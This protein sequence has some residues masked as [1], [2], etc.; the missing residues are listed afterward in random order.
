MAVVPQGKE[1]N[2]KNKF[3]SDALGDLSAA[4]KVF[5]LERKN[6]SN[7]G[8]DMLPAIDLFDDAP[9]AHKGGQ[10]AAV[11]VSK[12]QQPPFVEANSRDN[13]LESG[14][15]IVGRA[16]VAE[17]MSRLQDILKDHFSAAETSEG[18]RLPERFERV[19]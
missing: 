17:A 15:Q 10:E 13:A 14:K 16:D 3:A 8:L 5:A 6:A 1:A 9:A 11:R 18:Q 7:A 4:R 12:N 19:S 2:V